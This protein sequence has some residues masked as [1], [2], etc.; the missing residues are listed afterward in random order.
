MKE[1]VKVTIEVASTDGGE[2]T[3]CTSHTIQ[4]FVDDEVSSGDALMAAVADCVR[5][6]QWCVSSFERDD[7]IWNFD[8]AFDDNERWQKAR[9]NSVTPPAPE[10]SPSA[11]TQRSAN[12]E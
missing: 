11:H 4:R 3:R 10:T 5:V 6:Q 12:T 7:L 1:F 9:W 8:L 2:P